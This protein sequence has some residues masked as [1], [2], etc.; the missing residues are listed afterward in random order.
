MNFLQRINAVLHGERPDRV[1]YVPYDILVPRGDFERELRNRGM[2]LCLRRTGIWSEM[3]EVGAE[4]KTEGDISYTF[5]HTPKGTVRSARRTHVGRISDGE[6][7]EAE[8]MI[9]N[10]ADFEPV[11][12]MIENT[13]Y[14]ADHE[15]FLAHVRD[16]GSDG[17]V[18][19]EGTGPPYDSTDAYFSLAD[20][21]QMQHER[22][23][24]FARLLQAAEKQVARVM[25]LV[26]AAPAEL[27][28][29][30]SLSGIYGPKQYQQ[31]ALPFYQKYVP[32]LVDAGKIPTLHAHNSNLSAFVD[33][34]KRTGVPVIE[35][36]TP[37]PVGDLSLAD[38]RQA[39]GPQTVIWV[40]FP[41]TIFWLGKQATYDYT[42]D[43]L[44]Q[45][46]ASGRLVIGMTEMG[47][48]GVTDDESERLFK[49]GMRAIMD[50][51]DDHGVY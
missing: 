19:F 11:I 32:E 12:F 15:G 48:Y 51:I 49:D 21:A 3:P 22:P 42:V 24:D 7:I 17:I 47:S 13:T 14:H 18:R 29:L 20:W 45:D 16:V 39:W 30:G 23:E 2:G 27:V 9:K 5:H 26:A 4:Y 35:A 10:V 36:F 28:S 44:K 37:P 46:K 41:E 43:L 38:A 50:A 1:P 25:P 8:W 31:Y 33:H 34:V 40:N 6:S